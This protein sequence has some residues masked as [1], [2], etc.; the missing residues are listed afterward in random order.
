[1]RV[2]VVGASGLIGRHV[3]SQ[4]RERGHEVVTAARTRREGV[5][6]CLDAA[7]ATV[8]TW[9]PVVEGCDGVVFAAGADDRAV[10]KRPV[11]PSLRAGNVDSVVTLLTAARE[12]GAS[13]AVVLGSYFTHFHRAHPEWDLAGTHPYIRSRVEQADLGRA[14]AGPGLPVA[15]IEVPFVFGRAGERFPSW[16]EGLV[17]WV[18]GTSPLFAPPG[19]TAATTA[20]AVAESAVGALAAR[21]GADIPVVAENLTWAQ[22]IGRLAAAAGNP[23]PVRSLPPAVFRAAFTLAGLAY[24]LAG[25]EPGL[26]AGHVGRLLLNTLHLDGPTGRSVDP[27]MAETVQ[28]VRDKG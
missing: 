6:H 28:A 22:L 19:G 25:R 21:S 3:V 9:R 18:G 16:A 2:L 26:D 10:P 1:M 23:R 13:A 5:D 12:A 8:S 24:R 11:Y 14:A 27:A 7:A 17:K 4:L 15:V 20:S